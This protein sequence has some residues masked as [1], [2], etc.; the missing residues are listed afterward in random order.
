MVN[1]TK[2]GN[3]LYT[4]FDKENRLYYIQSITLFIHNLIQISHSLKSTPQDERR[5][6]LKKYLIKANKALECYRRNNPDTLYC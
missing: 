2:Q 3:T 4:Y 5:I 6:Q 1:C